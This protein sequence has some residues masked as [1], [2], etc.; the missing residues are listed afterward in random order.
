[1]L[2]IV[3]CY[4]PDAPLL[5]QS[6]AQFRETFPDSP[7]CLCDQENNPID[8]LFLELIQPDHYETADFDRMRNLNGFDCIQGILDFKIR[9]HEKFPGHE[10]HLKFDCDTLVMDG[11]W[12]DHSSAITGFSQ[13][14]PAYVYG[15]PR[16]MASWALAPVMDEIKKHFCGFANS[17]PED[18]AI[19]Y[20][21]AACFG[22]LCTIHPMS[23]GL[24]RGWPYDSS[25]PFSKYFNVSS[26]AFGNRHM[27][28]GIPDHSMRPIAGK[29]MAKFRIAKQNSLTYA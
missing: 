8:P 5:V 21:T 9:M 6:A 27:M 12:I 20:A 16:Y 25:V 10:G 2:G 13:G 26:L 11:G 23:S 18:Q 1:M 3:F 14:V 17:A 4:G 19:S 24:S 22:K 29:T 15:S 28:K 7:L